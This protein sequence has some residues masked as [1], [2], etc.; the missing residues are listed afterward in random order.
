[1]SFIIINAYCP[2]QI[3]LINQV[4]FAFPVLLLA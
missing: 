3:L 2:A 4:L 1:M